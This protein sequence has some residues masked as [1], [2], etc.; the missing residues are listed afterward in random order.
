M[1][2]AV[3]HRVRVTDLQ[4]G[5]RIGWQ[6]HSDGWPGIQGTVTRIE[7]GPATAVWLAETGDARWL[8]H[9][10][11]PVTITRDRA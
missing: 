8:I 1:T 5:D 2:A 7:P 3:E 10:N 6:L 9:G 11:Q 4:P